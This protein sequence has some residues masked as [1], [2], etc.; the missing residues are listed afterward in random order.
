MSTTL[1]GWHTDDDGSPRAN[2]TVY[3]KEASESEPNPNAIQSTTTT[4]VSGRWL[5]SGLDDT[6][7]WDVYVEDGATLRM[8]KALSSPPLSFADAQIAAAAAIQLTKLSAGTI[9]T[10]Y[11]PAATPTNL[12]ERISQ[13]LATA[14]RAGGNQLTNPGFEIWQRGVGPFTTSVYG[15]DRWLLAIAGAMTVTQESTI[16]DIGSTYSAKVVF[17]Y[18][19]SSLVYQRLENPN[20]FRSRTITF[21]ARVRANAP[22][23]VRLVI[24]GAVG[25][26]ASS[27]YHT[28]G[29]AFETLSCTMAVNAAETS[30]DI[31]FVFDDSVTAYLDNAAVVEGSSARYSPLHPH[32][33]MARC[34]RYYQII[35][36]G[37]SGPQIAGVAYDVNSMYVTQPLP[38]EMG[39]T[40][41]LLVSSGGHFTVTSGSP[42]SK[43]VSTIEIGR[44][45]S[46]S[47]ALDVG[48]A[49]NPF[50]VGD[51]AVMFA[52][53]ASASIALEW[54]PS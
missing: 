18:A 27:G 36:A 25:G 10:A 11:D 21:T 6:K 3:C 32:E 30:L 54:N 13:I 40:P 47:M 44:T 39:G 53:N 43:L 23:A 49:A 50:A 9:D 38:V 48:M 7:K 15:P 22:N 28:G 31:F 19:A 52:N 1:K 46:H 24:R 29:G 45:N 4:N 16:V 5:L 51:A 17:T 2:K 20:R 12:E 14:A 26:D 33:D 42:G 37:L 41:T 35:T 34:Q 8:Y